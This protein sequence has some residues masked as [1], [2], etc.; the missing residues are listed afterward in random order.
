MI[1]GKNILYDILRLEASMIGKYKQQIIFLG[2]LLISLAINLPILASFFLSDDFYLIRS[3]GNYGMFGI[4]SGRGAPFFRPLVAISIFIDY[5]LWGLN[6]LGYHL[7]SIVLHAANS[8]LVYL[9]AGRLFATAGL[10]PRRRP[11][12]ALVC[13]AI[14]LVL[15]SHSE[16]LAWISGRT[17]VLAAL[18]FLAALFY[19]LRFKDMARRADLLRSLGCFGLALLAKEPS[20]TLPALVV[21][22]EVYGALQGRR[23]G[24]S[25]VAISAAYAGIVGLYLVLRLLVLG[26][27]VGGYGA[28][29]FKLN[30][31]FL[32][33]TNLNSI[34]RIF[35]PGL[36][37]WG[38]LKIDLI[39]LGLF[40]LL[41]SAFALKNQ[42]RGDRI[43]LALFL[44]YAA[45]VILLPTLN[46]GVSRWNP[47][48]E[49]LLYLPS[50]FWIMLVVFLCA[51]TVSQA[52]LALLA[53]SVLVI[54]AALYI[55]GNERW[56]MAGQ[57]SR[58]ILNDVGAF[59]DREMIY[60]LNLPINRDGAH[61]FSNGFHEAIELLYGPALARRVHV[62]S[63][64]VITPPQQITTQADASTYAI[65]VSPGGFTPF[66]DNYIPIAE[67]I[68][69]ISDYSAQGYTLTF[70]ASLNPAE[71]VAYIAD[72]H[73]RPLEI[74]PPLD[75][76]I[77]GQRQP[78]SGL[79]AG[80][81]PGWYA[82]EPEFGGR[83][84]RERGSLLIQSAQAAPAI[85]T[86]T[87][88]EMNVGGA[89]GSSG[90][91][92]VSV[93]DGPPVAITLQTGI[94]SRLPL[95]L[96]AGANTVALRLPAGTVVPGNGEVRSLGVAFF[97]IDL[98]VLSNQ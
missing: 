35:L 74:E 77:N 61:M 2:F 10:D 45:L 73:L 49:R 30:P 79:R 21:G 19:Y 58:S 65:Q 20:I 44:G 7:F 51:S 76:S 48:G 62:V 70:S 11:L 85:L 78:V 71:T 63:A 34:T 83:W 38:A 95:E 9:I 88:A 32:I 39:F 72:G 40:S 53:G 22:Y 80:F 69:R 90:T 60:V 92:E 55:S 86:L 87:P 8:L 16:S 64:Q 12:A 23:G 91:L 18:G 25:G 14:F 93:N 43:A 89:L 96:R 6:P 52:R 56:R 98:S 33:S 28:V 67:P 59:S 24:R 41:A 47:V 13:G 4:W 17:D 68:Y 46:L 29:H 1:S 5:H 36:P 37:V 75:L 94:P 31:L 66:N 57:T 50:V 42:R 3:V 97:T 81:D 84:M 27:L 26:V 15:P 54:Y 82:Y